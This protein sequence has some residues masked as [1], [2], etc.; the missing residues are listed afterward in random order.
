MLIVRPTR[1]GDIDGV[2]DLARKA[3]PGMTSL[4]PDRETLWKSIQLSQ[5][6]FAHAVKRR[7]DFFLLVMEDTLTERVVGTAGIYCMT[8]AKQAFYAY[9]VMSL[10]H[11]SHSLG[12]QVRGNILH[13]TNDYTGCSEVG[14]LFVDPD[15][16]GNG[17]WLG[18]ARYMLLGLFPERFSD[19][20]IAEL[21]GWK[22]ECG[23]NPFWEALGAK[24]FAMSHEEADHL[25]A[26]SSN[27]FITELMPKYPI[28]STLLPEEAQAVIGKPRAE[29]RRAMELL[30]NEGFRYENVVD[31]FDA[32]PLMHAPT[33]SIRTI[34]SM[35]QTSVLKDDSLSIVHPTHIVA[36][37]DWQ[38]FCVM[39]TQAVNSDK[40]IAVP[41]E[42]LATLGVNCGDRL[43]H[44]LIAPQEPNP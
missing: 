4:P 24:F 18:R 21:R 30:E 41:P 8:G 23:D 28:Y 34:R 3:G 14:A 13:L 25:C 16:R 29:S 37:P 36:R 19:C 22:D 31:I 11:H 5:E 6:S 44:T 7:D 1:D 15:Y 39:R 20:V 10:T 33:H 35:Q 26:V 32:G 42:V 9:R 43:A 17:G 12:K 40:A 38:N 2:L 27:Q